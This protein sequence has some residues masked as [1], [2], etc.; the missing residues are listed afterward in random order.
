MMELD[1]VQEINEKLLAQAGEKKYQGFDPKVTRNQIKLAKEYQSEDI[2][3]MIQFFF[4]RGTNL[5]AIKSKSEKKVQE[6]ITSLQRKY[7]LKSNMK[8]KPTGKK[9]IVNLARVAASFPEYALIFLNS[10]PLT[11]IHRPLDL[12][13]FKEIIGAAEFHP[14]FTTNI[15]ASM[16]PNDSKMMSKE[17]SNKIC[18]MILTYNTMETPILNPEFR[19]K[20]FKD[21]WL[22]NKDYLIASFRSSL[23]DN[24]QKYQTLVLLNSIFVVDDSCLELTEEGEETFSSCIKFISGRDPAIVTNLIV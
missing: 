15:L 7:D 21:S 23:F 14:L 10:C 13:E 8:D 6:L 24:E 18:I 16:L 22:H 9:Q 17:T 12:S 2:V 11:D 19:S 3:H 5:T 20:T 4:L 1:K